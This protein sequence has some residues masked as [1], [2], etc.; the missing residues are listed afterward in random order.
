LKFVDNYYLFDLINSDSKWAADYPIYRMIAKDGK[1]LVSFTHH[2]DYADRALY[3][4][5][6]GKGR[7]TKKMISSIKTDFLFIHPKDGRTD[8]TFDMRKFKSWKVA[9][10]DYQ[11]KKATFGFNIAYRTMPKFWKKTNNKKFNHVLSLRHSWGVYQDVPLYYNTMFDDPR[12]RHLLGEHRDG[13]DEELKPV[14]TKF[15]SFSMTYGPLKYPEITNKEKRDSTI[16]ANGLTFL[17]RVKP[18]TY[19][20]CYSYNDPYAIFQKTNPITPKIKFEEN[21]ASGFTTGPSVMCQDGFILMNFNKV[22]TCVRAPPELVKYKKKMIPEK[23]FATAYKKQLEPYMKKMPKSWDPFTQGKT[24]I[25]VAFKHFSQYKKYSA[26]RGVVKSSKQCFKDFLGQCINCKQGYYFSKGEKKN[27]Y[28]AKPPY[29]FVTTHTDSGCHSCLN[30]KEHCLACDKIGCTLCKEGFFLD[31][32]GKCIKCNRHEVFDTFTKKCFHAKPNP[33]IEIHHDKFLPKIT[34]TGIFGFAQNRTAI[35]EMEMDYMRE[36]RQK[37]LKRTE[38]G[39]MVMPEL[40]SVKIEAITNSYTR[41]YTIADIPTIF[42]RKISFRTLIPATEK[43]KLVLHLNTEEKAHYHYYSLMRVKY[44]LIKQQSEGELD[45]FIKADAESNRPVQMKDVAAYARSIPKRTVDEF[46][47][48]HVFSI[49]K[50]LSP[51]LTNIS[52]WNEIDEL[53]GNWVSTWFKINPKKPEGQDTVSLVSMRFMLE[54]PGDNG[55]WVYYWVYYDYRTRWIYFWDHDSDPVGIWDYTAYDPYKWNSLSLLFRK[56]KVNGKLTFKVL[57]GTQFDDKTKTMVI[58]RD[59]EDLSKGEQEKLD[60]EIKKKYNSSSEKAKRKM[61]K[62]ENTGFLVDRKIPEL[63]SKQGMFIKKGQPINIAFGVK[64]FGETKSDFNGNMLAPTMYSEFLDPV[65][66]PKAIFYFPNN[67]LKNSGKVLNLAK[68]APGSNARFVYWNIKKEKFIP[69]YDDVTCGVGGTYIQ[70][71][72]PAMGNSPFNQNTVM[73]GGLELVTNKGTWKLMNPAGGKHKVTLFEMNNGFKKDS[74]A[75][76][77]MIHRINAPPSKAAVYKTKSTIEIQILKEIED[78]GTGI[79]EKLKTK[80]FSIDDK[81]IDNYQFQYSTALKSH[82]YKKSAD[83]DKDDFDM[84]IRFKDNKGLD[85]KVD[86]RSSMFSSTDE[87]GVLLGNTF[88]R[89]SPKLPLYNHKWVSF[90]LTTASNGYDKVTQPTPEDDGSD[91]DEDSGKDTGLTQEAFA[92]ELEQYEED[93]TILSEK[94]LEWLRTWGENEKKVAKMKEAG[95]DEELVDLEEK[96]TGIKEKLQKFKIEIGE[97]RLERA[98]K[99]HVL[100][101]DNKD[102]KDIEKYEKIITGTQAQIDTARKG[103]NLT[104]ADKGISITDENK[105]DEDKDDTMDVNWANLF[106]EDEQDDDEAE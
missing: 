81:P 10:T 26:L 75:I 54:E 13:F 43:L 6:D 84:I 59:Q 102:P 101:I 12:N 21:W 92:D 61:E 58:A 18:Q 99:L 17:T 41:N 82:Y 31:S 1:E 8:Y 40:F 104:N 62:D 50:E 42:Q 46:E 85:I 91:D 25:K 73:S 34:T 53:N 51:E 93:I 78:D 27:S 77:K 36:Q 16:G 37:R 66:N 44:A 68:S 103:A 7:G 15:I 5:L 97:K 71:T 70:A 29:R 4:R 2:L 106:A 94:I 80:M 89:L 69:F 19:T 79:Y 20:T 22:A 96:A 64:K 28:Q 35:I 39:S 48:L 11:S 38:T 100:A 87:Y 47:K 65:V 74:V 14:I 60:E 67:P 30:G 57:A 72:I 33:Y 56:T 86:G 49:G 95:E 9:I 83:F 105:S 52:E 55:I 32:K 98:M 63:L 24:N 45:T 3:E 23:Y 76:L 90:T 88:E